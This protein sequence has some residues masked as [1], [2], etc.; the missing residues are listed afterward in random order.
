MI[1][2][3]F[4]SA[5]STNS[6]ADLKKGF[7]K[8]MFL[9]NVRQYLSIL[10]CHSLS[11]QHDSTKCLVGI[12]GFVSF[13]NTTWFQHSI[14]YN[15]SSTRSGIRH[16]SIPRDFQ[17][18]AHD[19]VCDALKSFGLGSGGNKISQSLFSPFYTTSRHSVLSIGYFDSPF[20]FSRKV[21]SKFKI[22][23]DA[24]R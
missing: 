1:V 11:L 7:D 24:D 19:E 9:P 6:F 23:Q 8:L 18:L 21:F 2:L 22:C 10:Q 4:I 5:T 3:L 14:H 16:L 20:E 15:F 17:P 12:S 13:D